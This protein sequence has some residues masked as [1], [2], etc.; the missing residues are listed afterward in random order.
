M[1]DHQGDLQT[2]AQR[3]L[4]PR[5]MHVPIAEEDATLGPTARAL[6]LRPLEARSQLLTHQVVG[7]AAG[8][9]VDAA[10]TYSAEQTDAEQDDPGEEKQD[11]E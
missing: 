4:S 5:T 2:E 1:G 6:D 11:A 9:L 7:S 3:T 8:L 10:V